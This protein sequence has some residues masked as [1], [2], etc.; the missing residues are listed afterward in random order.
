[1]RSCSELATWLLLMG[2]IMTL[3]LWL[4]AVL[5]IVRWKFLVS[6]IALVLVRWVMLVPCLL[7]II[8]TMAVLRV[9]VSRAVV[10]LT[11][12]VVLRMSIALLGRSSLWCSRVKRMARQPTGNLV[13]VLRFMEL[14]SVNITWGLVEMIRVNLLR[15]GKV[16]I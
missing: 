3:I 5:V 15:L 16:V 8:V 4:L 7:D 11:L 14:G 12:L 1:M 10:A 2:L 9:P 6:I 13:V